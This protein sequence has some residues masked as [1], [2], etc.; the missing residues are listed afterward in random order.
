VS[1]SH[2]IPHSRTVLSDEDVEAAAEV[3]RSGKIGQMEVTAELERAAGELLG[4]PHAWATASGSAAIHSALLCIGIGDGDEV[5][6]PTYVCDDV[7]SSVLQTGATPVPVDLDPADLNPDPE[8]ARARATNRTRAIVLGHVLGMPAR[9]EEFGGPQVPVIEDLAHG[10]G[11]SLRDGPAGSSGRFAVL[12]FHALK[13]ITAGQGGMVLTDSDQAADAYARHRDPDFAAGEYRLNSRT[14]DVQAAIALNQLR[15]IERTVEERRRKAERYLEELGGLS[16]A[17]PVPIEAADGRGSSC[18]RVSFLTDEGLSFDQVEAAF[19]DRGVIVRRP[20]KQLSHR[21]L[22]LDPDGYPNA[23]RLFDRVVSLPLYPD[24][25]DEEQT[26]V[27][28]AAKEVL[29]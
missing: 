8:D 10:V 1:V 15:R 4:K 5:L 23:E 7:I 6:I 19:R 9:V 22:K 12:S 11:G 20:V 18:Y 27:I 24:L 16:R 21:S 29:G 3:L 2:V 14:S 13:M 26:A 25:T 17:V 28:A